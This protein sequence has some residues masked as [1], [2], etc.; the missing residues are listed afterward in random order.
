M[1]S[2]PYISASRSTQRFLKWLL[3]KKLKFRGW[4][5]EISGVQN[6]CQNF[7]S[8]PQAG[9][10]NVF[11]FFPMR[12][13]IYLY[14]I[15]VPLYELEFPFTIKKSAKWFRCSSIRKIMSL[16]VLDG[17]KQFL[18]QYFCG[19]LNFFNRFSKDFVIDMN[20]L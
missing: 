19:F 6:C 11:V 9:E 18:Y 4:L 7:D 17:R 16:S 20:A 1:D 2:L 3:L 8:T 12:H 5:I 14:V 10:I 13:R 15:H